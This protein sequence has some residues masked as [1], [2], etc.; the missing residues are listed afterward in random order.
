MEKINKMRLEPKNLSNR[1]KYHQNCQIA[2]EMHCDDV[3]KDSITQPRLSLSI[4]SNSIWSKITKYNH[5]GK[6]ILS[7]LVNY[8]LLALCMTSPSP[9]TLTSGFFSAFYSE[10]LVIK[11]IH[12]IFY[13]CSKHACCQ[14]FRC[15]ERAHTKAN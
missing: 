1:G 4:F 5:L 11:S 13:Q 3:W 9:F 12:S 2:K 15:A 6:D 14:E 8:Q 10:Y 7:T